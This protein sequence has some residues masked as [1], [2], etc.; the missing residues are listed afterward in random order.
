MIGI[1]LKPNDF[2]VKTSIK[3]Y[4]EVSSY[5]EEHVPNF[6]SFGPSYVEE[7]NEG[8]MALNLDSK[9]EESVGMATNDEKG[10]KALNVDSIYE[11]QVLL[12]IVLKKNEEFSKE[13]VTLRKWK[14]SSE[15]KIRTLKDN[16][17]NCQDQLHQFR[18]IISGQMEEINSLEKKCCSTIAAHP[19]FSALEVEATTSPNI[20]TDTPI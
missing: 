19:S 5:V 20:V 7:N 9:I 6:T 12:L 1:H 16:V 8:N 14:S 15:E 3:K 2:K 18:G 11:C 10:K 17:Q 4:E 13:N